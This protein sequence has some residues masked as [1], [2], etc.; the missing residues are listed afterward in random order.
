[1]VAA[2][3]DGLVLHRTPDRHDGV[4]E[5]SLERA[6]VGHRVLLLRGARDRRLSRAALVG[7]HSPS[8]IHA[9]GARALDARD[10]RHLRRARLP[11]VL[12]RH[13]H[14]TKRWDRLRHL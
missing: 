7:Y 11:D 1:M 6:D 14:S 8:R 12:Q 13:G 3:V 9:D 10:R 2:V 5:A 4:P